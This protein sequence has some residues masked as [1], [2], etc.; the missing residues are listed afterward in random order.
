MISKKILKLTKE[1][2]EKHIKADKPELALIT[3]SR[4]FGYNDSD[5]DICI[6]AKIPK[7]DLRVYSDFV[8]V[9]KYPSKYKGEVFE[10]QLV[11]WDDISKELSDIGK[12]W[13]FENTIVLHDKGKFKK[14]K[15][16]A[17]KLRNPKKKL[18]FLFE[19]AYD[20]YNNAKKA[21]K[22]G[23]KCTKQLHIAES[24]NALVSMQ[25]LL[26]KKL[27]PPIKWR[28]Y[29]LQAKNM[30]EKSLSKLTIKGLGSML[31]KTENMVLKK[32]MM[33]KKDFNTIYG[34]D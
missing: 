27:I 33:A 13:H 22:R 34:M 9:K 28:I 32:K 17:A 12:A 30:N 1:Y 3:G 5:I 23:F 25:Y 19:K 2:F 6:V 15:K 8:A 29:L 14:I 11:S 16:N 31:K 10:V 4:V 24:V 20:N 21:E 18:F 26:N 7:K